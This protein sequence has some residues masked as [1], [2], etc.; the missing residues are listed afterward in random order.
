M[1][2]FSVGIESRILGVFVGKV[3]GFE[4]VRGIFI[5][6]MIFLCLSILKVGMVMRIFY[7]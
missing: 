5:V 6:R 2:G 7:K 1:F 4:L 3:Y